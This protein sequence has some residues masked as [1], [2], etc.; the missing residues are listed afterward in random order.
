MCQINCPNPATRLIR[1]AD[2]SGISL[3]CCDDHAGPA[4]EAVAAMANP[5]AEILAEPLR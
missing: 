4:R 1:A 2:R 5:G 3:D